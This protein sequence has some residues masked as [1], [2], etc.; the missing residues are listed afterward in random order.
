MKQRTVSN[1]VAFT[2]NGLHTG[3][4]CTVELLPA[5]CNH[6]IV[7]QRTDLPG[8]PTIKAVSD[9]ASS[10]NRNTTLQQGDTKIATLEH[11]MATFYLLGIDNL[12]IKISSMELPILDGS[13]QL[14]Y[15]LLENNISEQKEEKDFFV[16]TKPISVEDP[17]SGAVIEAI[18]C[19]TPQIEVTIDFPAPIGKH[20]V[21]YRLN[22][23]V[24]NIVSAR[25]FVMLSEIAFLYQNNLIKGGNLSNALVFTDVNLPENVQH[26]LCSV[27]NCQHLEITSDSTLNNV[28]FRNENEPAYHKLLDF[29]GDLSL[30]GKPVKGKI[31][32]YKPGHA[33]NSRFVHALMQ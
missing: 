11:F 13:A 29:I 19:N 31:K 4:P 27:F 16:I 30:V 25:T 21:S 15:K 6:G 10:F 20:T 7:F 2:G 8:K 28:P 23:D 22:I 12:L 17:Q 9:Y 33:V 26:E 14:I 5:P 24:T 18:P 32:A 1:P 3:L